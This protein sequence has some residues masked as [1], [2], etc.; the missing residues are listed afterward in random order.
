VGTFRKHSVRMLLARARQE[1]TAF[2]LLAGA[3]A[4]VVVGYAWPRSEMDVV[5]AD[6]PGSVSTIT[7]PGQRDAGRIPPRVADE[8]VSYAAPDSTVLAGFLAFAPGGSG[9]PVFVPAEIP[10]GSRLVPRPPASGDSGGA[11]AHHGPAVVLSTQGRYLAFYNAMDGDFTHLPGA[12]CGMVVGRP[13]I[14]R[15]VLGGELVQ[16]EFEGVMHAVFGWGLSRTV[17]VRVARSMRLVNAVDPGGQL[18]VD[19]DHGRELWE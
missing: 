5:A 1:R 12:P 9:D 3:T 16:W 14:G 15:R 8:E 17:V 7:Q 11:V 18:P 19:A 10:T 6:P 2:F 4:I 13:A